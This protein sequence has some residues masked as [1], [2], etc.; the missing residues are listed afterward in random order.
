MSST[1][2]ALMSA[3]ICCLLLPS[4]SF[5]QD[6]ANKQDVVRKAA[7]AYYNLPKEGFVSFQ[8][9]LAPNYDALDPELRKSNPA[10]ADARLKTL[11]QLHLAV[12]VGS[13]GKATVSHNDVAAQNLK[14]VA[15]NLDLMLT[16]FFQMWS[17]Y[18]V[19]SPFPAVDSEYQLEDL[20]SQYRL[21]Y[22][23]GPASVTMTMDKDA[24]VGVVMVTRPEVNSVMWPQFTKTPKGFLPA[25]LDNDVRIP[26]QGGA[27]HV[28]TLITYQ[29]VSGLQL[30]KTIKNKV[31][32]SGT[33]YALEVALTGCSA[34]KR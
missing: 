13:D 12:T 6:V 4:F 16:S 21:S 10:A 24:A 7:Q 19:E 3:L 29:E 20:G 31:T 23:E 11:S 17:P 14:D 34:T 9:T 30:P 33:S 28:S 22:K 25:S 18:V 5:A 1:G 27:A 15:S 8:C 32:S 2:K 26:S